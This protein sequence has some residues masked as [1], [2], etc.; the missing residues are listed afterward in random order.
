MQFGIKHG[1][2]ENDGPVVVVV[3]KGIRKAELVRAKTDVK[4][5]R[6][7]KRLDVVMFICLFAVWFCIGFL[8]LLLLLFR[9]CRCP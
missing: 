8:L 6:S 5:V 7:N 9:R 2:V 3:V 1:D 4:A